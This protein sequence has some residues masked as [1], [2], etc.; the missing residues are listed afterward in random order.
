ME[1][2]SRLW[3]CPKIRPIADLPRE[4]TVSQSPKLPQNNLHPST[5]WTE[6]SFFFYYFWGTQ[7][8]SSGGSRAHSLGA[9]QKRSEPFPF[10]HNDARAPH[11]AACILA[12]PPLTESVYRLAALP[13]CVVFTPQRARVVWSEGAADVTYSAARGVELGDP[14]ASRARQAGVM[15]SR[16][17][18]EPDHLLVD[19]VGRMEFTVALQ[20]DV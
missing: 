17:H 19:F 16:V 9:S 6:S 12:L 4:H 20:R 15:I 14:L 1:Y 8:I 2:P 3:P 11:I 10:A 13:S 18:A 7:K 5:G